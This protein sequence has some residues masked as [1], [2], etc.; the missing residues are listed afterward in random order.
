[1]C[2]LEWGAEM[3]DFDLP[4]DFLVGYEVFSV[5]CFCCLL[6]VDFQVLGMLLPDKV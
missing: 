1:M 5:N 6:A 4:L 3:T 2:Q